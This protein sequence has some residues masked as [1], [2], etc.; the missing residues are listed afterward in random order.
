M[1]RER[2][3]SGENS[4]PEEEG[5]SWALRPKKLCEYVGQRH[6]VEKL[7]VAMQAS[8]KRDEPLEHVLLYGPPGLGKTTL[9]HIIAAEFESRLITSSG[10]ALDRPGDLL[11]ILTSLEKGDFLFIDEIHRM[12]KAVEEYLYPAIEDFLV[13]F[14]VDKGNFAKIINIPIKPF[15]LIGATTRAGMLSDPLRNRFGLSYHLDFY[16]PEDLQTIIQR[17]ARLLNVPIEEDASLEIGRRSRGTPRIANRLLRRVRDYAEVRGDG[18]IDLSIAQES[19]K[20][21]GI[22]QFGLDKLDREFIRVIAEFYNCGPVGIEAIAATLNEVSETLVDMVE[23]YLLKIGFIL[24]TKKGRM[25]S[26]KA[27]A[28]LDIQKIGKDTNLYNGV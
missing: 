20:I 15:T 14:T 10:P 26:Q 12:G 18:K 21:E 16:P 11:G 6:L 25:V 17:S 13:N 2:I 19:L 22:D 24:R 4:T 7:E 3:V 27:I 8:K 28:E 9:S 23:P 1:S 5:F